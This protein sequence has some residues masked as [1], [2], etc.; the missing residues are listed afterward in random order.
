M[1]SVPRKQSVTAQ[2]VAHR[3]GVSR[4]V[5]SR[6]LSNNGSISPDTRERVLRAAEELG[7]Q[8]NF[9]AQGLN[10]RRSHLVGVI[11]S[12][13]SD[14]FR[15]SLLDALLS[16]I[17]RCGF[18]ALVS[19]IR[20]EKDLA[21]TLRRFS[22]FRV[23]GVI[24]TSG[25]P[26]ESLVNECVS[27]QI[28]VVGINRQPGIPFVDYVSSDNVYGATL[29]AG[30]LVRNGCH[31][32]GWLNTA[33][34][35]W[36]GRM[37]GDA[38]Y[39]ALQTFG[40]DTARNLQAIIA[41]DEGY[42]GGFQ[43]AVGADETLDGI[44]CANAQLACGFLDG[45]RQRGRHAPD[46]FQ[47]IGFDNTPQTA[48]YSYQLTTLHQ[49]VAEISRQALT[50]LLERADDPLQPSR[51]TWVDVELISRRTSPSPQKSRP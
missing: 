43:A 5:V 33:H 14:P 18:Q 24:V 31:S 16:E 19:E 21:R 40:I 41:P 12:R 2:D 28:P 13:I 37:R 9:L 36:A 34:S 29:A 8:V 10:R 39:Q 23:S 20:S 32:F 7:Y 4:A 27:Q 47:L 30:Q 15:S 1:S 26:P 11:V 48:Q 44:F 35:T 6:A 25:Q 51:T 45:M 17:Q 22:Q 49:D 50:R 42:D 38:F 46:D 3:A